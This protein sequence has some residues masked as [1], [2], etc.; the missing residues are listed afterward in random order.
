MALSDLANLLVANGAYTAVNLDG[1]GSSTMVVEGGNGQPRLL[2][3]PIDNNV[4]GRERAVANH[5]GIYIH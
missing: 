2:N 5:V 4:P 1:G 3:S